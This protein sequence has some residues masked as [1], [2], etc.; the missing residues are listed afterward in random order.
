MGSVRLFAIIVIS[1]LNIRLQWRETCATQ[2]EFRQAAQNKPNVRLLGYVDDISDL[3]SRCR[4]AISPI[5]GTG[6]KIKVIEA[7]AAGKPVFGSRHTIAGLPLGYQHCVF[8]VES[9]S[10]SNLL[11]DHKSFG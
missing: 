3:Y 5:D 9:I 8:P 6:L 4:V 2:N 11:R 10:T 7:L 1:F